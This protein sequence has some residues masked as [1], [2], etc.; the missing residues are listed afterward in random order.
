MRRASGKSYALTYREK[1][2]SGFIFGDDSSS[3]TA[4]SLNEHKDLQ[5]YSNDAA[6]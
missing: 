3:F 5:R 2:P 1:R 6:R 4:R